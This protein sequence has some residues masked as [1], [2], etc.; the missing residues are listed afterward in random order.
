MIKKNFQITFVVFIVLG[1]VITIT[2]N[3][4]F[5]AWLGF[6]INI[7]R[8][9]S[10]ILFKLNRKTTEASIKY[11]LVQALASILLLF[12]TLLE[13]WINTTLIIN[14]I[15]TII[16]IAMAIKMG[17]APTHYWFPQVANSLNWFNC[18][19]LFVWQKI[20]PL[21]IIFN[22]LFNYVI[23]FLA[24][25]SALT[26][27]I[28]GF[29]SLK[30][31]VLITFSS[32]NHRAWII[33]LCAISRKFIFLYFI[34]YSTINIIILKNFKREKIIN[35]KEIFLRKTSQ[36]KKII[37]RFNVIAIAGLPPFLGFLIKIMALN[38][39]LACEINLILV[40]VLIISSLISLFFY[41]KIFFNQFIINYTENKFTQLNVKPLNW[42]K[43][44]FIISIIINL[45]APALVFLT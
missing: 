3:T 1:T 41:I 27:R 36:F 30:T 13:K 23:I 21:V 7:I 40:I 45:T 31:K 15:N 33:I 34:F 37:L 2:S 42:P 17:M 44:R 5:S 24:T 18:I 20:A 8:F 12:S 28:G 14:Y 9:L 11:F 39:Y 32:I 29:N 19:L 16:I 4:L 35:I 25:I 6:E 26:G 22:F 38:I 10:L 43:L